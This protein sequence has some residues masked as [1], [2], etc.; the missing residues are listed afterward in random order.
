[1]SKANGVDVL[2]F[3]VRVKDWTESE[4]I[5]SAT[6]RDK[7]KHYAHRQ[8]REAGYDVSFCE[9]RVRRAPKYDALMQRHGSGVG[10]TIEHA[11]RMQEF[12]NSF[13]P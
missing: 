1:M 13:A 9:F 12:H 2:A 11:D 3:R 4:G 6:D 5:Y 7:A 10:W 8:A